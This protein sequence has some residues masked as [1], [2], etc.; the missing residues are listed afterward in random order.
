MS[1]ARPR[2][3]GVLH[4]PERTHAVDQTTNSSGGMEIVRLFC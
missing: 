4:A 2:A 1:L 3:P